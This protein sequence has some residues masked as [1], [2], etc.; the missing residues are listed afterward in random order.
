MPS[1]KIL[2]PNTRSAY[3]CMGSIL[4]TNGKVIPFINTDS[5]LVAGDPVLFD[6]IRY[7]ITDENNVLIMPIAKLAE[8]FDSETWDQTLKDR[9]QEVWQK[10]EAE[11]KV[12]GLGLKTNW[13]D[14]TRYTKP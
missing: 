11:D 12:P 13:S 9:W 3:S 4:R 7:R 5:T 6:I 1:G 8:G 14:F 10:V 2:D